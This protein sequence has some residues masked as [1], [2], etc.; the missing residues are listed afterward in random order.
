[1]ASASF[2][3]SRRLRTADVAAV[4]VLVIGGAAVGWFGRYWSFFFDEWGT[5]AYRRSG[6][7]SAFLAPHNGHLV[8]MEVSFYR[9]MFATVGL[10]SYHP[11]LAVLVAAHVLVVGLLFLYARSRV[12]PWLGLLSVVPVLLLGYAWQVL[13]WAFDI[14]WV[15]TVMALVAILLWPRP[16]VVVIGLAVA[17]ATSG[18]GV[19]VAVGGLVMA[20]V[21]ERRRR[22]LVAWAVPVVGY[23]L[24]WFAYR[25][26][27]L[28][29]A[30]LRSIP[31]ASPTGDVGSISF[32]LSNLAHAPGYV[33][34]SAASAAGALA[35]T[36][37]K[38]GW[39]VLAGLAVVCVLVLGVRRRVS[40]R[41][42]AIALTGAVFWGET[43]LT[44]AQLGS[45][46]SP[47]ASR[48]LYPGAVLILL[49]LL[50]AAQGIRIPW[51]A[52]VA[53]AVVIGAVAWAGVDTLAQY[54]GFAR[55]AFAQEAALLRR[56]ECGPP[57]PSTTP[58]DPA[59]APQL[60]A[61]VYRAAVRDLG[62]PP[63]QS[64]RP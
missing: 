17:L 59:Q 32:P 19:A 42:V 20:V 7:A 36:G 10:H 58:L 22:L 30:A 6:G 14:G 21:S 3:T 51:P 52:T 38:A 16:V 4:A 26:S 45:P 53:T 5:I 23:A 9:A 35:S 27:A 64:C 24:W 40:P 13:F 29:P 11:Y 1:M 44:R 41:L 63:G 33:L 39:W 37:P 2:Q 43:A 60:T 62:S 50:E 46:E 25:P 34:R 15:L 28:T 54:G 56:A 57:L 49:F 18:P 48:Y 12:G 31:G 47:A 8:A 55:G 61:G